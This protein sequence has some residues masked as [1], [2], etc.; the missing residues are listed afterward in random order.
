A[1]LRLA[2]RPADPIVEHAVTELTASN[3][4]LSVASLAHDFGLST[5]HLE[6]RFL[7]SVGIAPKVYARMQRFQSVW[8]VIDPR[9]P[10]AAAAFAC[11]YYAQAHLIR[12]FREFSG[13]PPASLIA[14]DDLARHFLSHF[15]KTARPHLR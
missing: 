1:L 8:P 4:M 14:T 15:S 10:W 6:R 2:R 5:R 13:E 7:E 12:D 9:A 11:G 3:G